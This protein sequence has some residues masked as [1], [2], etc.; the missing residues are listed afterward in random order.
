[1]FDERID[2]KLVRSNLVDD[3]MLNWNRINGKH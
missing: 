2:C 1:M 3:R